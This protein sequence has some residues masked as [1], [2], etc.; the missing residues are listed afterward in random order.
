MMFT[1]RLLADQRVKDYYQAYLDHPFIKG[2]LDGSL[3]REKYKNYLIQDTHYLKDYSKVFANVY[4]LLDNVRDLQFLH[5][6]IGVVMSE[7]TNMHIQYLKD[8][9]LDVFKVESLE[10]KQATRDYLD[11]MLQYA[12]EKNAAKLF[13]AALPCTLTYEFIGKAL[14]KKR[15]EVGGDN[16]YDAW[17]DAYAGQAFEDFAVRSIELMNDLVEGYQESDLVELID[18]FVESCEHEMNFWHMSY[19]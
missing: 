2:L 16:Y 6:C 8:Y 13:C 9:D 1:D 14:K 15:L 7:E 4:L 11:F 3:D 17:I 19:E 18:I 5:T 10:E 12:P